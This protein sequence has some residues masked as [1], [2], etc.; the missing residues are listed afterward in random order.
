M[1]EV[2]ATAGL[3][4]SIT[5][6]ILRHA[7]SYRI[8]CE[9]YKG[10]IAHNSV[11]Q[12]LAGNYHIRQWIGM[13]SDEMWPAATKTVEALEKWPGSDEPHHTGFNIAHQTEKLSFDELA[14]YPQ[15]EKRYAAAMEW[16]STGPGLEVTHII[17]GLDW[18]SLGAVTVVDVG[19]SYGSLSVALCE[20]FSQLSCI[21]QDRGEVIKG[22]QA[23]LSSS[24]LGRVSFMEHDF[25]D[26]QPV[27]AAGVYVL[28][29]VLHDWSDTYAI[30]ILRALIPAL[31]KGSKILLCELVLDTPGTT[32][33]LRERSAR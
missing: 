18:A 14:A 7:I 21:V 29:W 16:F 1:A 3:D 23:K 30:K 19:G 2:A 24:M 5:R 12:Y 20:E 6:R 8:F 22:A 11:S 9:P 33:K 31:T 4:E 32:S 28:R 26:D 27:V 13:V 25:F 10:F 15:R 17:K